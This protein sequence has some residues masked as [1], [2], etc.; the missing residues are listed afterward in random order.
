M[1]ERLPQADRIDRSRAALDFRSVPANG[2]P[3]VESKAKLG[4]HRWAGA[5]RVPGRT[6][7]WLAR[8]RRLTM[9]YE[10]LAAMYRAF[11]H[12]GCAVT[13]WNYVTRL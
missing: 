10:R 12:L 4:R 1:L 2:G 3:G 7:A 8:Y 13:C 6:L 11:L 5:L 9:R